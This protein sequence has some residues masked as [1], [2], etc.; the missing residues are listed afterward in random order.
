MSDIM[1]GCVAWYHRKMLLWE[2]QSVLLTV[3]GVSG[4]H[5]FQCVF[6]CEIYSCIDL[7]FYNLNEM[8][9]DL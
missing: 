8:L 5:A 7:Y 1:Y 3:P 2:Q 4:I 9:M 6:R